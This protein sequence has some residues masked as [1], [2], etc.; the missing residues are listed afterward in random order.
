MIYFQLFLSFFQIGLFSFGGGYAAMPL[1]QGQVVQGHG[2]LSMSE[3]TDLITISQMTPGP[4]AV[5]SATFVGIKIAGIPG[6]LAATFGCILPSC[7]LVTLLAK[8]YLKYREMAMLQGILHSLRPAVVAMIGS[9]GIS[10]LVTAFWSSEGDT[11]IRLAQTNWS[12]VVIFIIS[13]IL[14]Q[15]GKKN[16]IFVMVLA[17]VMKV[18]VALV[19][20][21]A[22]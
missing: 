13:L 1:I 6:A 7:I 11:V 10:I 22:A 21:F 14:L 9:A 18:A 17:G 4:I 16:P 20:K 2:W 19:E 15:K 3:F 8:L 5:N 12:L